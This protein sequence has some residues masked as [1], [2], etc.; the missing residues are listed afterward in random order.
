MIE[1]RK[2]FPAY[3]YVVT[4][5]IPGGHRSADRM[6]CRRLRRVPPRPASSSAF[7]RTRGE[8][9]H[10]YFLCRSS[11]AKI[12]SKGLKRVKRV[13]RIEKGQKG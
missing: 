13:K 7:A 4:D 6:R 1:P 12:V 3:K 5:D 9:K 11:F 2:P 8:E 10:K